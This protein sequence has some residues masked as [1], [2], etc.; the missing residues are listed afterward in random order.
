LYCLLNLGAYSEL[1]GNFDTAL[2]YAE[3]ALLL[4]RELKD[5]PGEAWAQNYCGHSLLSL[6]RYAEA[7]EA[8]QLALELDQT[9][10][11]AVE[12]TEPA[13]GLA[14]IA[15]KR[16]DLAVAQA[17]LE[18][19]LEQI[20]H[21]NSLSGTDQPLRVYH[22]CYIVL[23]AIKNERARAVLEIAY[24]LLMARLNSIQDEAL[25]SM[26]LENISYHREILREW[27]VSKDGVQ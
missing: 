26:F 15:L 16:G 17:Y 21:D 22:T 10:K 23:N 1:Q 7:N 4:A 24:Q 20:D 18:T 11:L 3:Q 14:R 9:L 19:I 12:A 25:R 13:A 27:N 5:Q 2:A 6:G 8:Y